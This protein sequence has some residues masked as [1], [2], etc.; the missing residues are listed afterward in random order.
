MDMVI[1]AVKDGLAEI[2]SKVERKFG[3]LEGR[4]NE[5][6]DSLTVVAQK[7]GGN[8]PVAAGAPNPMRKLAQSITNSAE[9]KSVVKG[10]TPKAGLDFDAFSALS[11]KTIVNDL[12]DGTLSPA[13]RLAL[14]NAQPVLV[15]RVRDRMPLAP[16]ISSTIEWCRLVASS[17]EGSK[18]LAAPQYADGQREGVPK[19]LSPYEF[20]L[21]KRDIITLAHYCETSRQAADDVIG[22]EQFLNAELMDGC[23]RALEDQILNGNG[24]NGAMSGFADADN[25]VALAGASSGDSQADLIRRGIAQLQAN[26]FVADTIVM[27]PSDWAEIELARTQDLAYLI[28]QPRGV[29]P[30]SLWGVGVIASEYQTPG[31]FIVGAFAQACTLFVRQE[32]RILMSDSH[33]E[34]FTANKL[35]W[36]G[37]MRASI[38]VARPLGIVKGSF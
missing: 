35:A 18:L 20:E 34:N 26:S 37:E 33:A 15:Q 32:G 10:H 16:A 7:R 27:H 17:S 22:L 19:K 5:I 4:V 25:F 36:L 2:E 3:D 30:A 12:S 14:T 38:A 28:G 6:S 13:Q 31:T 1:K 23:E 11:V 8:F 24:I 9:F 21:V 29:N